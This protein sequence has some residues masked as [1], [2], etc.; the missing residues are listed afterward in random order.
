MSNGKEDVGEEKKERWEEKKG[1]K[2]KGKD[3][4]S[5][6]QGGK[7]GGWKKKGGKRRHFS[8][9][10]LPSCCCYRDWH[11]TWPRLLRTRVVWRSRRG[12]VASGSPEFS[13]V[14]CACPA[15]REHAHG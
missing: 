7:K 2:D 10:L 8:I 11:A 3:K 4:G 14:A 13:R 5:D 6:E 1:I 12:S 9:S 15:K